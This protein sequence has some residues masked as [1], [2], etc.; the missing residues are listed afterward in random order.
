VTWNI[1]G[2]T[3]VVTGGNS[4]IGFATASALARMEADVVVTART[5][6]RGRA[7]ADLIGHETGRAVTPMVLD[8]ASFAS[9]RSFVHALGDRANPI[10]VLVNNAGCYVTPRRITEDGHEWTMAVNHLG[11]FLLTCLLARE[12]TT[13]P[14]RIVTVASEA[15]RFAKRDLGFAQLEAPGRYRGTEAYAR[16]KLAN[17]LFTRE[18]ARR[19]E[20][21]GSVAFA[22]HPGLVASRITQDGD[23][24]VGSIIWRAMAHRMR[25]PQQGAATVVDLATTPGIE[26][27][28][29]G[30]FGPEGIM[31]PVRAALSDTTADRL[32]TASVVTVG[33]DLA[34][35]RVSNSTMGVV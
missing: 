20:G 7:A 29:G 18:L 9:V 32:W 15:H 3:V 25:T 2:R 26:D 30:Y 24:R 6:E 17:I 33:C 12:A 11:P 21:T 28:S 5:R 27:E 22:A 19:L 13:R 1:E 23:S 34:R 4:G 16:S 35:D 10:D 14:K 31:E 8:L